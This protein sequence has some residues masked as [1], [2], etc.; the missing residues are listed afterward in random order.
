MTMEYTLIAV[1]IIILLYIYFYNKLIS[2]KQNAH[3]A[4]SGIDVQLKRR[5]ELIPNLV[6]VVQ[7][8]AK[9]EEKLFIQIT[10]ERAKAL[11][12]PKSDIKGLSGIEK[13]IDTSLH[14]ILAI[15][16]AYPDLKANE[17]FLKLQSQLAETEDQ[18]ASARRI[19]NSNAAD[20]NILIN[21]FPVNITAGLSNFSQLP[22]FQ[23]N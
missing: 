23:H 12:L 18:I 4:W 8:Y 2:A 9:H 3:E 14:S 17:N 13:E 20:Y 15:A 1:V 6:N 7:G 22:Y 5:H 19:Y 11:S 10:E 16:E 21:S